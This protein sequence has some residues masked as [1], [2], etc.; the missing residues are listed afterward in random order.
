MQSGLHGGA[1]DAER[2]GDGRPGQPLHVAQ[3]EHRTLLG[4]ERG[5]RG[6]DP[7]ELETRERRVLGGARGAGLARRS[8]RCAA[9]T[10]CSAGQESSTC[11]RGA[12][13]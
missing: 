11:I 8:P 10:T 2:L 12:V 6:D 7:L 9:L 4:G 1:A 13:R 3:D 5:D